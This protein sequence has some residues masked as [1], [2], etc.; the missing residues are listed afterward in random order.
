MLVQQCWAGSEFVS[1]LR[2]QPDPTGC[3][4][5]VRPVPVHDGVRNQLP[6][7]SYKG[8]EQPFC[9]LGRRGHEQGHFG[10][11]G[12]QR[13]VHLLVLWGLEGR[14]VEPASS[15]EGKVQARRRAEV[16]LPHGR[17]ERSR[18]EV[19]HG[20]AR[21]EVPAHRHEGGAGGG[22][23]RPGGDGGS[24]NSK[25]HLHHLCHDREG[26]RRQDQRRVRAVVD[27]EQITHVPR[28]LCKVRG[29]SRLLQERLQDRP[30][31]AQHEPAGLD[32]QRHAERAGARVRGWGWSWG[33]EERHASGDGELEPREPYE[34]ARDHGGDPE[35]EAGHGW[36]GGGAGGRGGGACSENYFGFAAGRSTLREASPKG[37]EVRAG[38]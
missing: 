31:E 13:Q 4:G 23:F 37:S 32:C 15:V 26:Q 38:L 35:R 11:Q 18:N 24:G 1:S 33:G 12:N 19:R 30:Q 8:A 2:L 10:P 16:Q 22:R 28:R 27:S 34:I 17:V 36:N 9:R 20:A 5:G 3:E 21:D 6:N 29:D 7:S 25:D 14:H